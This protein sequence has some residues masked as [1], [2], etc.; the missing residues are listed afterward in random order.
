MRRQEIRINLQGSW[1]KTYEE[2]ALTGGV[3]PKREN[4]ASVEAG[5]GF[6]SKNK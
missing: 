3:L 4:S 2:N 5:N 1:K 6:E